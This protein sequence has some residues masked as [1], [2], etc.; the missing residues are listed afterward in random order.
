MS[1]YYIDPI[2]GSDHR[3]GVSEDEGWRG[4]AP[5]Q[6]HDLKSGDRVEI[7]A[8]GAFDESL[9]L[10]GG[11]SSSQPIIVSFAP[12][13]YDLFPEGMERKKFNISNANSDSES[14]KVLAFYLKGVE[15][16]HLEGKGATFFCRGKMIEICME[17]CDDIEVSGLSFD[18]HR[19]TVSEWKVVSAEDQEAEIEVH[20][21]ST[22]ELKDGQLTWVGEGWRESTGLAQELIPETLEV[23]RRKDPLVGLRIEEL[24][25][26][27][28]RVYGDHGMTLGHI[29][30][31]RNPFRDCAGVFLNHSKNIV[32][33]DVH[34][35]FMHGMGVLCQF[36]ENITL[37]SV[38][39]APR[40]GSGRTSAAWA[41]CTHFSGCRGKI[42]LRD[43]LFHGAHDDA[44]NVHGTHLRVVEKIGEK[45][46]KVAFVHNQT[47]G[48]QAFFQGDSI[49]YVHAD[50]LEPFGVAEV[51]NVEIL[52][53]REQLLTLSQPVPK[54]L[55]END[56][57][58]NVTWT[59]HV[60]IRGCRSEGIPTRGFLLT[61]RK[62]VV[63]CD[64][65]FVSLDHGIHIE[66]D[67]EGWFESGCVREMLISGNR[68]QLGKGPAIRISP[69][70]S[71]VNSEVH[72]N[73]E[74]VENSFDL[75]KGYP[76]IEARGVKGL[77]VRKNK[78]L[79]SEDWEGSAFVIEDCKDVVIV[80]D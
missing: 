79:F 41:D 36:S 61:T 70:T 58:E 11:G 9:I 14:E 31:L 8:P 6:E 44:V 71:V 69:H 12:G 55:R 3:T 65:T 10:R 19:P 39:I 49:E 78:V 68:F 16:L 62:K 57:V 40:E 56:V 59:P 54:D 27:R 37:Q 47:Y 60:E 23:W 26:G 35:A 21:D 52:S 4:F 20:P 75:S 45:E 46:I 13:R 72:Q 74:V 50:S 2:G 24:R 29:F 17:E 73:I 63:V 51:E 30:Q 42:T 25:S 22:Y 34:F 77:D 76:A 64:N 33:E 67:A 48:F 1:T 15:H 38:K 5:L 18:Y 32:F 7:L 80:D 66:S 28:L 43:C 53:S